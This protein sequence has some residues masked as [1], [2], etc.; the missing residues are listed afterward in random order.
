LRGV[1]AWS[2]VHKFDGADTRESASMWRG[3]GQR[4]DPMLA[5]MI[6]V[7]FFDTKLL[8]RPRTVTMSS[9]RCYRFD[10]GRIVGEV[11][12]LRKACERDGL[13]RRLAPTEA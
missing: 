4:G 10:A 11:G 6:G 12:C 9:C 5:W 13:R 3:I 2:F 8:R 1:V 7:V